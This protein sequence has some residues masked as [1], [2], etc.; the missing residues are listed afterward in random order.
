MQCY[1]VAIIA[2]GS[3]ILKGIIQDTNSH[4]LARSL[5]ELGFEVT[6]IM[7]VPDDYEDI[8][9]A[10]NAMLGF[11]DIIIT[12]GGLG[13]TKDDITLD[14]IARA[15]GLKLSLNQE[16]V[17][18]IKRRVAGNIDPYL[19]AAFIPENGKPLFNSVGISPG[20]YLEIHGKKIIVLPGV[21]SEM[22]T[23]FEEQVKPILLSMTKC[24]STRITIITDHQ[25]EREVDNLI[26][27]IR[28]THRDVYFKTHATT[29]VKL[30]V[31][32]HASSANEL[33]EKLNNILG[34]LRTLI[35]IREIKID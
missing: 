8:G 18:M 15:L 34:K 27:E 16:A 22:K 28:E 26:K 4:W 5:T 20:V 25:K 19:K 10:V 35:K 24:Y 9:W 33:E 6:R 7:V 12:T 2:I 32:I 17:D 30:T 31:V 3:E 13:F 21:P 29:P 23:M 1:R 11:S 14:A